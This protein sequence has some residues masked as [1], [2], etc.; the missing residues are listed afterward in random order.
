MNNFFKTID[1]PVGKLGLYADANYLTEIRFLLNRENNKESSK[2]NRIINITE[3]QLHE[4]FEKKR[5][6]FDI[7]ILFSGTDFQKLVWNALTKIEYAKTCTYAQ[8]ASIIN[9]EKSYRAVG[10]ANNKNKIPIIVPC[11]RVIGSSGKLV[12][13]AGG[14]EIKK[15]LLNLESQSFI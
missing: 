4:Y 5:Y 12:G 15:Y 1:S 10:N 11:H 6:S 14:L 13:Y 3:M 9:N 8:I 7:P 2:E